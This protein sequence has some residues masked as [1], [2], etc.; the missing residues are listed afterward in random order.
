MQVKEEDAVR[1]PTSNGVCTKVN[2]MIN[3]L[4]TNTKPSELG[5]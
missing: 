3:R 2:V 1:S 4:A 5:L